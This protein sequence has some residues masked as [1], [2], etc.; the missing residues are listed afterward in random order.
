M[1]HGNGIEELKDIESKFSQQCNVRPRV[2]HSFQ[3]LGFR[4]TNHE[5]LQIRGVGKEFLLK[6]SP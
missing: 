3:E 5:R 1:E 4:E 6:C 2:N